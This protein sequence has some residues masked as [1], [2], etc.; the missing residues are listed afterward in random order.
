MSL[1]EKIKSSPSLKKL[2]QWLLQ[3]TN[4]YRPR[5]WIRNIANP[6][7]HKVSRKAVIRWSVRRDLFPYKKFEIGEFSIIEDFC[8][9]ANACGDVKIGK[10]VLIGLGSKITGPVSFGD[11]ILLAQ[12]V[13][14]SGLNHDFE[15][16]TKAIVNQG[17]SVKEI[18]VEDGVWIGASAVVTAGVRIGKNSVVG[19][20]SVVTKDI[21]PFCV[22]VGNP[23]KV[24][25]KYDFDL[26]IWVKV[27]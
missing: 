25:K 22:A 13:V 21:P 20:G 11:N 10:K 6:F 12:N 8:L 3:P 1:K 15:D 24:I 18:V 19:A 5:W 7:V 14:M 9:V 4:E 16:P 17:F 23:A 27:A 26:K 2:A